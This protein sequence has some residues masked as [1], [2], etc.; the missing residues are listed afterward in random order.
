MATFGTKVKGKNAITC[1]DLQALGISLYLDKRKN[2]NGE[3]CLQ[4]RHGGAWRLKSVTMGRKGQG[5]IVWE[6]DQSS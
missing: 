3:I 5:D 6:K 4:I 2:K 1:P